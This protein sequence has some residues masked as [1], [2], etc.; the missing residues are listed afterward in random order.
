MRTLLNLMRALLNIRNFDW[1]IHVSVDQALSTSPEFAAMTPKKRK[2][3]YEGEK[4]LDY[5]KVDYDFD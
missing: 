3:L 1:N 5:F 4:K 2:C